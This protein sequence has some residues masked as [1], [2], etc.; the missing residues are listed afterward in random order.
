M[1]PSHKLLRPALLAIAIAAFSTS[2]VF[3]LCSTQGL[4]LMRSLNGAWKGFGAVTPIGGAPE[5][6]SCRVSYS[7]EGTTRINQTIACAGTDYKIEATSRI[8]CNGNRLDGA[9][10]EKTGNNISTAPTRAKRIRKVVACAG[11][12]STRST[13]HDLIAD[14]R[15][16]V[17]QRMTDH[18]QAKQHD[19]TERNQ[20]GQFATPSLLATS[21][22]EQAKRFLPVDKPIR[23]L[24]PAI[25]TVAFYSALLR[26][27]PNDQ[28]AAARG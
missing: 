25:G 19:D 20:L 26:A 3:A 23:F 6:V 1:S 15:H 7:S 5:R 17:R 12:S 16:E 24:D 11:S 21:I 18:R 22:L 8:T 2:P 13:R 4:E 9:F 28:I 14:H 10:I 27:V